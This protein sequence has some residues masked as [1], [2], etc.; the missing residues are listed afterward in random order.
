MIVAEN[1]KKTYG[2]V[3]AIEDV[4]FEVNEGEILGFL[5]PNGAGKTTTMRILTGYT[6]PS[7]GRAVI[8]GYDLSKNPLEVRSVIGYL[9]ENTPLYLDMDVR[10][11]LGFAAQVKGIPAGER[12]KRI[13][14]A[15][16][17]TG[18]ADV[19]QRTIGKLSKGYRQRVGLAQALIGNPKV[20]I[21]DEPTVGLDPNQIREIRQLI[22]EMAGKRT[23]ILSTHILPEVSMICERVIIIHQGRI[24]AADVVGE[25]TR[26]NAES[27]QIRMLIKAPAAEINQA[28]KELKGIQHIETIELAADKDMNQV[29]LRT[30]ADKDIRPEL[31]NRI[32]GQGWQ[33]YEIRSMEPTLE[34]IFVSIISREKEVIHE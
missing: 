1:L 3:S 29:S 11:F 25:L 28:L 2:R 15:M 9:P 20:L 13:Q 30:D 33:V 24:V 34:D 4:S 8:A 19:A 27:R 32:V 17:E 12:G 23:V 21:L 16:E 6:P 10:S 5:G 7:G 22:K 31:V 18:T 14:E 26:R